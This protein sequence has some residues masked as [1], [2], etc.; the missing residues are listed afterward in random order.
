MRKC[1]KLFTKASIVND[2]SAYCQLLCIINEYL[3]TALDQEKYKN[4]V[5]ANQRLLNIDDLDFGL[6]QT[7]CESL[8]QYFMLAFKEAVPSR[9]KIEN[10]HLTE[11]CRQVPL[12]LQNSPYR[13]PAEKLFS[14][15]NVTSSHYRVAF[16][17]AKLPREKVLERIY[18]P[19]F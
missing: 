13:K 14:T 15:V 4:L 3:E 12:F 18:D 6:A 9:T 11:F 16:A 2:L 8:F 17:N 1:D 19:I 7:F 10:E 5:I